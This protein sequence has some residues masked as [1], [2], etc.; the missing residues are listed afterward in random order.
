MGTTDNFDSPDATD[1][2]LADQIPIKDAS[3][4]RAGYATGEY[5]LSGLSGVV[6]V[7]AGATVLAVTRALHG[8]RTVTLSNTAPIAVTLPASS[9][10]GAVYRLILQAAATTTAS[11]IKV[12]NTVDVM[13]GLIV[14]LNTTAGVVIGFTNT[15]SS[16]T[17]TLNGGTTGGGISSLYEFTDAKS[18]FWQVRGHDTA[19]MTTTPYSATV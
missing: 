8:N 11:T 12:A 19:A 3:T 14:S 16:D 18:G 10:S 2:G 6:N 4:S 7:T 15:A 5:V 1:F 13:Q 17:L 9:G